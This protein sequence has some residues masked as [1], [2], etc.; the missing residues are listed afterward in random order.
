MPSIRCFGEKRKNQVWVL[1]KNNNATVDDLYRAFKAI[2]ISSFCQGENDRRW[3]ATLDWLIADTKGC[4][5]R[6]LEGRYAFT[7]Q[8]KELFERLMNG[9]EVNLETSYKKKTIWQDL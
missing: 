9:E 8:E 7:P 1:L 4:F 6:L 2:S 5:N 3:K